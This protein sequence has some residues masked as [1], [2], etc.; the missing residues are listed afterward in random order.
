M[1]IWLITFW[2]LL[3]PLD[4]VQLFSFHTK[5]CKELW[6]PQPQD[7]SWASRKPLHPFLSPLLLLMNKKF[8]VWLIALSLF[9]CRAFCALHFLESSNF[10]CFW[11]LNGSIVGRWRWC[12]SRCRRQWTRTNFH[13]WLRRRCNSNWIAQ[14]LH[15]KGV[16]IVVATKDAQFSIVRNTGKSEKKLASTKFQLTRR[17]RRSL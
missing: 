4:L 10:L 5:S 3:A 9:N 13:L 15:V 7:I 6:W 12:R 1:K 14:L 8:C 2:A 17:C 16:S 11:H